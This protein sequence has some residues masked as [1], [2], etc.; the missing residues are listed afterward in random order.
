MESA[1]APRFARG[2]VLKF[3]RRAH[4]Y[5]G[6]VMLPW[7]LFFGLSGMLFNHPNVGEDVEGQRVPAQELEKVG[8]VRPWQA[9]VAAA[10]V[11]EALNAQ[12]LQ[13]A[14]GPYRLDESFESSFEGVTLLS[15]PAPDGR[16]LLLLD[17]ERAAGVLVTRKRRPSP[18]G[19]AFP[20]T[21]L[22]LP[23]LSTRDLEDKLQG[24][25]REL[26]LPALEALRAHPKIAPELRL[27]VRDEGG[28]L[29][30]LTYNT[31]SGELKGR[32]SDAFPNIG[33]TQLF[34]K[35]HT[36]HHFPM[37]VGATFFWA[38]FE[39][40]LG[41]I[42]VFWGLS[43]LVM[44]WQMKPTRTAGIVSIVLAIGVALFV[45][46]GTANHLMFGDVKPVMG[47]GEE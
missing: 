10:R 22:E 6:L 32:R 17:M 1:P 41:L 5:A 20:E 34:A 9:Q 18:E 35:L 30:N 38:V 44:W 25:L 29:W 26:N 40:L 39:D 12:S 16:Y 24:L 21:Q 27:R 37:R 43:G 4:M 13:G 36:T 33:I 14:R 47:P 42:M 46:G 8:G 11:V 2:K 7:V 23:E 28:Q 3:V 31:S 19:S 45:M 15:A